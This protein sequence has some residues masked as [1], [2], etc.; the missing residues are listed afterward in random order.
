MRPAALLLAAIALGAGATTAAPAAPP[1]APS[2]FEER[3]A[4]PT[5]TTPSDPALRQRFLGEYR[6]APPEGRR[7]VLEAWI[8]RL[9]VPGLLDALES[10][11]PN[12]H[13]HAHE[14]GKAAYAT[15]KDMPAVLQACQTRCVSGCMHGV[16]MEAFTEQPGSLRDRIA[17]LCDG[18]A[19]RRIH[20][21]GD[22]VHGVGHGAAY[23]SNYDIPRALKLCEAVGERAYQYYCAS[24][25]YMQLFM[26]YQ[27]QIAARA[28]Q[29]PCD[30]AK[31]YAAACYRYKVFFMLARAASRGEGM[32]AVAKECLGLPSRVQPA[33]FHGL[34]HASVGPVAQTPSRIR[35][36]C[37]QGPE[38]A[39]WLCIQGVVEKLAEIDE[40]TAIRV[41]AELRG[42][43]AEVCQ[44]AT[45]NKL[46]GTRKIGLDHYF[47]GR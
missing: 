42:K 14:L 43:N 26:T 23:V 47:V 24:G 34:G 46:Y 12:C 40:P 6:A 29:Y 39:Q 4:N 16:L 27:K 3:A 20:K 32:P 11:F 31:Q 17:T 25:A 36:I 2:V 28:D 45:R 22:C 21:K 13:D 30:E 18:E 15:T 41:C 7:K 44:E 5:P 19:F 1:A 9:G 38:A 33:C 10:A 35:E 8:P 37:G